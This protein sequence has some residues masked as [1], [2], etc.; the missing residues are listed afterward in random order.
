MEALNGRVRPSHHLASGGDFPRASDDGRDMT[1][2]EL[3]L[4][5][6][7]GVAFFVFVFVVSY[8]LAGGRGWCR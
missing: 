8:D 3:V 1:R 6:F 7:A 5:T 4:N 2:L